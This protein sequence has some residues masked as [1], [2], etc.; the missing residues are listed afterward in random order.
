M[1]GI[2]S[3]EEKKEED[4]ISVG[5]GRKNGGSY[6]AVVRVCLRLPAC[7][8]GVD[9]RELGLGF[10]SRRE[11]RVRG[12]RG[13]FFRRCREKWVEK[14]DEGQYREKKSCHRRVH[15]VFYFPLLHVFSLSWKRR[16]APTRLS[17]FRQPR[18]AQAHALRCHRCR[19]RAA[20]IEIEELE[21]GLRPPLG[22]SP[23][24][25]DESQQIFSVFISSLARSPASCSMPQPPKSSPYRGVTLFR[26]SGKYR[27]QVRG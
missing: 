23:A 22:I 5:R 2:A 9:R 21:K 11:G 3:E 25:A 20:A 17:P 13:H 26:P 6:R 24:A 27:A 19:A 15:L 12:R 18:T 8:L 4:S 1:H 10:V 7:G 14:V 16:L